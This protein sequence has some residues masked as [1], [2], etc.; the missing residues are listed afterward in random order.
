MTSSIDYVL[1]VILPPLA[2]LSIQRPSHFILNLVLTCCFWVPGVIHALYLV[3]QHHNNQWGERGVMR[4]MRR[5]RLNS[6][7]R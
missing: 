1:A 3:N 6:I 7:L 5:H 2:V 4:E